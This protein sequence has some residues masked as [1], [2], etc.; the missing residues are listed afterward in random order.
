MAL[1]GNRGCWFDCM[2]LGMTRSVPGML[3]G[4]DQN[5]FLV[6]SLPTENMQDRAES[7]GLTAIWMGK[8][9]GNDITVTAYGEERIALSD[10]RAAHES[11]FRDWMEV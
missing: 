11:F 2:G 4:E 6:T 7:A 8:V 1:A 10:L 9:E 5:R 3:F